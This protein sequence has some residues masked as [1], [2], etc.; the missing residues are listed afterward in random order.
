[1]VEGREGERDRAAV[2]VNPV[3]STGSFVA[4]QPTEVIMQRTNAVKAY[5]TLAAAVL[6]MAA[7]VDPIIST[8]SAASSYPSRPVRMVVPYAPGGGSDIAGRTIGQKLGEWTGQTFIV[9]NRPGAG[10]MVG[11]EIVARAA[12]D[13]YTIILADMP[14]SI[15]SVAYSKPRYD[16]V[17]DFAPISLVAT[18]PIMWVAHPS[19]PANS[20]KEL[21][22]MAKA[23]PGKISFGTSGIGSAPH[24]TYEWLRHRTGMQLNH[25]P[26]KGGGPAI[27]DVLANHI[28]L[29]FNAT[30]PSIGHVREGR[31][32]GIGISSATRHPLLP[33]VPTIME[34]GVP[35]FA[36][37]HWYGILATG[38][39]PR[40]VVVL[41]NGLIR[42]A[43]E[44]PDVKKRFAQL[45][46]D[47]SPSSPE[48][49]RKMIEGDVARWR[50]VVRQANIRLD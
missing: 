31:M 7:L 33:D 43:L 5:P 9:D 47:I 14:H 28:P 40:E 30:P 15:N 42:K 41:L 34:A 39:T 48:A 27:A 45:A 16:A 29:A 46:L 13:G 18:A 12:P 6:A 23:Q 2:V 26:Y 25:V 10:S 37:I 11:T 35:D 32:K 8:A 20:L 19:F 17:K 38:G 44:E 49:F 22:A 24:M 21:I 50:D 4:T 36:L 1:M 3:R